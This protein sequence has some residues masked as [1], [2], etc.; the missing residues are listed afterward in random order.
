MDITSDLLKNRKKYNLKE[1]DENVHV[2]CLSVAR[3]STCSIK[4]TF[5]V[6]KDKCVVSTHGR[7]H[8]WGPF[9]PHSRS[10]TINQ[11]VQ[12]KINQ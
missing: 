7:K 5:R 10:G 1:L 11:L 8:W 9:D 6:T 12:Q 4:R 2:N 3:Q